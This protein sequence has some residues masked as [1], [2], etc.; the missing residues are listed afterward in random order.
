MPQWIKH[1]KTQQSDLEIKFAT[2]LLHQLAQA[3]KIELEFT[4]IYIEILYFQYIR[5]C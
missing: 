2:K 1:I 5:H 3:R 4:D